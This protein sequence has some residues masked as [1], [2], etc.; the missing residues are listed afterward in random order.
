VHLPSGQ[1][2]CT[3]YPVNIA[4]GWVA[5]QTAFQVREMRKAERTLIGAPRWSSS[6]QPG[7]YIVT[8]ADLPAPAARPEHEVAAELLARRRQL[9]DALRGATSAEQLDGIAA[10][11]AEMGHEIWTEALRQLA[12]RRWTEL[13][14]APDASIGGPGVHEKRVL[15][16][17]TAADLAALYEEGTAEGW[18][19]QDLMTLAMAVATAYD[20]PCSVTNVPHDDV[21]A[22]GCGYVRPPVLA[23]HGA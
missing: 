5:A 9:D 3:Y 19:T 21:L 20:I 4:A 22:C 16:A 18:W 1:G 10:M 13:N 15:N 23:E 7:E 11:V 12:A 6:A 14:E 2:I 8:A 17:R